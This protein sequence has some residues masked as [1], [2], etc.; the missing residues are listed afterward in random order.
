MSYPSWTND[1][2][3]LP[4]KAAQERALSRQS[5]LTKPA[6]SL[7]EMES[8]AVRL[9]ALQATDRP[10]VERIAISIFAAD[11]GIASEGVSAFPQVVTA[12]MV[13]NFAS[14]GAAISVLARQLGAHLR[15][16]NVGTVNALETITGVEDQRIGPG[17]DNFCQ[18]AAMTEQQLYTAL[19]I[20]K[21]H[22]EQAHSA[23]R[24]IFIGGEMGIA[25]TTSATALACALLRRAPAELTGPGTGINPAAQQHKQHVIKQ[26]LDLHQLHS[27]NVDPLRALRCVGGF[28]I[29]ALTGS[30]LRCGQLGLA[31][32]VDGFIA[33]V[34]ALLALRISPRLAPWLLLGHL[35]AEPGHRHVVA[36]LT[37][38]PLLSLNMR[39]GEAS[40]A[41]IALPLLQLACALHNDMATF[42]SANISTD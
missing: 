10:R 34:A 27:G 23:Q 3:K 22:A 4:C 5:Q 7:G 13:K 24:D 14:G 29:A 35:S 19:T 25:N 26:A 30:Y 11:H 41:T 39:L 42:S 40:G 12:E 2:I 17:T 9:A 18:R 32:L 28:E 8:I 15:V 36:A 38:Q 33:S 6:G 16:C 31:V 20:G 1:P 21:T 37:T